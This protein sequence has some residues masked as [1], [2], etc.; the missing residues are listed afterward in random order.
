M[1]AK[2]VSAPSTVEWHKINWSEC[3]KNVRRLQARIVKAQQS[4]NHKLVNKLQWLLTHSFSA[5]AIAVKRVTE[6]QGSVTPGVDQV[7]LSTPKQKAEMVRSLKRRGYKA[8]PLRRVFIPKAN[9]KQRPLGIPTMKDRAMQ[10]LYLLALDPIAE[11]T[12][13][14]NSYGFRKGRGTRDAIEHC[15]GTLAR[16]VAAPWILDADIEGCFDHISHEWLLKNVPLDKRVLGTWLKAGVVEFGAL[17][18]TEEGTPQGGII[19]P[20]LANMTLNGMESLLRD[21]FWVGTRYPQKKVNVIR[22]ADD[23]VV[24]GATREIV[25]EAREMIANF[26]SKRGLKLSDNKTRIVHIEEGFD[27]LGQNIRK[28]NGKL[29]IRPSKKNVKTFL[30]KIRTTIKDNKSATQEH[31]ISLLNPMTRGWANYHRH[32]VSSETFKHADFQVFKA[33]WKWATRRHPKKGARWVKERYFRQYGTQNWAFIPEHTNQQ[34]KRWAL[35]NARD[36]KIHRHVK[37]R[38]DF[39]PYD[40]AWDEY[41]TKRREAPTSKTEVVRLW[42][43]Q[44]GNCPNCGTE[45]NVETGY[46]VHHK[47]RRVDGG[48]DELANKELLHPNCHRQQHVNWSE[49]GLPSRL[50]TGLSRMRGNSHVRFLGEEEQ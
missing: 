22:Y 4:G 46:N 8:Q 9:G 1:N 34:G 15:F 20:T 23:F 13:D 32:V 42:K 10:A 47:V 16:T 30:K 27:F 49:P 6:N 11:T 40:P 48:T 45:I 28:F 12:A 18:A 44:K 39:N 17:K 26:L 38:G 14:P 36:T 33:L 7:T 24:T 29:L 41:A 5:K 21:H 2:Q 37:V 35:I 25:E 19:S 50:D 43:R 3:H 31:L